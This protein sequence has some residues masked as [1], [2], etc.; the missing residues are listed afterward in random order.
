MSY[1]SFQ[2]DDIE[3]KLAILISNKIMSYVSFQ[4]EDI[5]TKLDILI[6]LY[7]EDRKLI[8]Q[9]LSPPPEP[10]TNIVEI[11]EPTNKQ[12]PR[13]ILVDNKQYS[14]PSSPIVN[15]SPKLFMQRNHSDLGS[16]IRK[17]V[18]YRLHSSPV[19]PSAQE[20]KYFLQEHNI[21]RS[22]SASYPTR[23][24]FGG[25]EDS[26]IDSHESSSHDTGENLKDT[27]KKTK[28]V[29]DN[30]LSIPEF[31]YQAEDG[32]AP[33]EPLPDITHIDPPSYSEAIE[34]SNSQHSL[35]DVQ[36]T[37]SDPFS[38]EEETKR[39][40]DDA[41]ASPTN[42]NQ[43]TNNQSKSQEREVFYPSDNHRVL[44][45][46]GTMKALSADVTEV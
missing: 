46:I 43:T 33:R 27:G 4:V 41:D 17:R 29:S 23:A 31:I 2:V 30:V 16:R 10:N 15:R 11:K 9:K 45:P 20:D 1:L 38:P 28:P 39:L 12:I 44:V 37:C 40:L 24:N 8:L 18:T 26:V 36:S 35:L 13:S 19:C 21:P 14:E 34:R 25:S 5:E 22:L 32:N 7:K 6:D 42:Q 3:T